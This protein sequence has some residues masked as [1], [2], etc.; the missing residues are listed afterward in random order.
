MSVQAVVGL[1]ICLCKQSWVWWYVCASSRRFGDMSLQA[2]VGLV[3]CLCKQSWVWWYVCASSRHTSQN[4]LQSMQF[5]SSCWLCWFNQL[6]CS[7]FF[8]K[9]WRS[10]SW[11][12]RLPYLWQPKS[13]ITLN[14]F[15]VVA[16]DF[17]PM[18]P[19]IRNKNANRYTAY[20][21]CLAFNMTT[22]SLLKTLSCSSEVSQCRYLSMP[23]WCSKVHDLLKWK[24]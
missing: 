18:V 22:S 13:T 20:S 7:D 23:Y 5:V 11:S 1:V 24:I 16:L 2:V 17:E 6:Y 19:Q 4:F 3:I 14:L 21:E 12:V 8:M 9:T 15:R 10:L